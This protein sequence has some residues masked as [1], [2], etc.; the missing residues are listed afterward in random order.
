MSITATKEGVLSINDSPIFFRQYGDVGPNV[1]VI[2]GGPGWDHT[3][4]LPIADEFQVICKLTYFDIRAC[5]QSG[6]PDDITKLT[7]DHVVDDLALLLDELNIQ[8]VMLL[9][10]AELKRHGVIMN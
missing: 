6:S 1:V 2:H 10:M 5:G 4:L 3:Y 9:L 7:V 8:K